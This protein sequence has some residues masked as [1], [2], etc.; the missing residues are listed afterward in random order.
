MASDAVTEKYVKRFTV[1][2]NPKLHASMREL[3]RRKR[4]QIGLIYEEAI[5]QYL[6]RPENYMG[7]NRSPRKMK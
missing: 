2:L 6:E 7:A 3:S 5:R 4:V 1:E